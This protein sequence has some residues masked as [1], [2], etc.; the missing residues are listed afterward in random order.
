[1]RGERVNLE[2]GWN[3]CGGC[4]RKEKGSEVGVI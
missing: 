3:L 4:V 1:M 2:S